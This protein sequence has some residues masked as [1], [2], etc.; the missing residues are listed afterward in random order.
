MQVIDVMSMDEI[1]PLQG[2]EDVPQSLVLYGQ[3]VRS[4]AERALGQN[5]VSVGQETQERRTLG[6]VQLVAGYAEVRVNVLLRRCQEA[7][8]ELFQARHTIWKRTLES[9]QGMPQLRSLMVGREAQAVDVPGVATDGS[10]TAELLDGVFWGKPKGSVETADLNRQRQDFNSF[11]QTLPALMQVNQSIGAVLQTI[12]A[13]RSLLKTALKVNRVQDIQ[14]IVGT[15]ANDVF[16]QMEA[17]QAM[18]R[19]PRMQVLMAVANSAG[20]GMG[21]PGGMP[22]APGGGMP[23]QGQEQ[24]P[25]PMNGPNG[26]M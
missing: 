25:T 15:E 1:Q 23:P 24:A 4:D 12:P 14:S 7:L 2:I 18:Q 13:A 3:Q 21:A 9:R 6:E 10:I 8:E 20:G 17:Q 19:D 22:G 16:A 11:L 5:D 26:V